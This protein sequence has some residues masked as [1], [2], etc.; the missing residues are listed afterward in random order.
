[1]KPDYSSGACS[2]S[3]HVVL[4]VGGFDFRLERLDPQSKQTDTAADCRNIN[5]L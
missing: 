2:P 3:R 5:S 4:R 1:M